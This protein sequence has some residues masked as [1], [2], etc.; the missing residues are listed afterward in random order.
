MKNYKSYSEVK[1]Q[2]PDLEKMG[3]FFAFNDKQFNEGIERLHLQG[4]KLCNGLG[5]AIGTEEGLKQMMDFYDNLS[6]RIANVCDPQE[7]YDYEFGNYE[8]DY[9]MDD[10]QAYDIVKNYFGKERAMTVKR[11]YAYTV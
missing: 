3:V 4:K 5:G 2:Q 7:V 8:C 11:K 6:K 1:N 10:S 9:I